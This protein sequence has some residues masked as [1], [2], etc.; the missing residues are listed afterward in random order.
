VSMSD[1]YNRRESDQKLSDISRMISQ[2][3][4][5][6]ERDRLLILQ[7]L[8]TSA[9]GSA[10][11]ICDLSK[12]I[13]DA[14]TKLN[15]H[16]ELVLAGKAAWRVIV[17]MFGLVLTAIVAIAVT[18]NKVINQLESQL[19]QLADKQAGLEK[20]ASPGDYDLQS[21]IAMQT[22]KVTELKKQIDELRG[23]R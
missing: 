16:H 9:A 13:T 20:T 7:Y 21:T 4:D 8:T 12:R 6:K 5:P 2:E 10:R 11:V 19:Y 17:L 1:D 15:E 18:S 14:S 23:K 3:N 22:A